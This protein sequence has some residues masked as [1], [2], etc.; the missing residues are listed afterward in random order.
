MTS[1]L[2]P[3][4]DREQEIL[5]LVAKGA[6][7][8]QIAHDLNISIN[9]VKV[10]LRN[11]FSKIGVSS[12]TEATVYAI[13]HGLVPIAATPLVAQV[14]P[15]ITAT[16]VEATPMLDPEP[17]DEATV[18]VAPS[19]I[20]TTTS[21]PQR[22]AVAWRRPAMIGAAVILVAALAVL[23]IRIWPQQNPP[24]AA[25]V[26]QLW[27]KQRPIPL[28]LSNFSSTF[29]DGNIYII[30]GS[31]ATS[32]NSRVMRYSTT[33]GSWTMLNE[34]KTPVAY[35]QA[36]TIGGKI[37]IPGGE[38]ASGAVQSSFESYDPRTQQWEE[39]PAL[40]APRSRYALAAVEGKLYLF[41]GWDGVSNRSEVFT[42]N[43]GD[44]QWASL[45]PMPTPRQSC[46]A[47]LLNGSVYIVGGQD[48]S[49]AVRAN[50]RFSPFDGASGTWSTGP[51]TPAA[52]AQPGMASLLDN[53]VIIDSV[54]NIIYQY[55]PN[56]QTW[57][58]KNIPQDISTSGQIIIADASL[59]IF[60]RPDPS[61]DTT[62]MHQYQGL[63]TTFLPN[64]FSNP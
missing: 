41:G 7:N 20:D 43:P 19:T 50:E 8:Q 21:A 32:I 39:L 27:V 10:H 30:G 48:A 54:Q 59:F 17:L 28:A 51:S 52:I 1:D 46:G 38:D 61:S 33:D 3:I 12:R 16:H 22:R 60:G 23:A 34:K 31:A 2:P 53:I 35:A 58:A 55:F 44:R 40:P 24:Q 4:S 62:A 6:T 26:A 49:G 15:A 42:Y 47:A 9:T 37:Y 64:T 14:S 36:A 11:I 56:T 18:P 5:S 45:A 63:Y 57:S 29:Y 13:Q 25:E